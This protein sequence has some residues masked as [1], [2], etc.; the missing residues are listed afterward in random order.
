[1]RN[2]IR[3]RTNRQDHQGII[4][5]PKT[6][7]E[8]IRY[9]APDGPRRRRSEIY[10]G[11]L[12]LEYPGHEAVARFLASPRS[13]RQFKSTKDLAKHFQVSRMTI[14]RWGHDPDVIQRAYFLS[15]INQK[16]GDLLA[17]QEWPRIMHAAVQKAIGGDLQSIKFC[18]SRA[19]PKKLRVEQPNLN[20]TVSIQD[21][22]GTTESDDVQ[23]LQDKNRQAEGDGQ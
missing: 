11:Q 4:E 12:P 9:G 3:L 16:A 18:E 2:K 6:Q 22:L 21:L 19:Y 23:E 7:S 5:A 1:M 13:I 20:A 17:R 15:E 10:D 14:F 8:K